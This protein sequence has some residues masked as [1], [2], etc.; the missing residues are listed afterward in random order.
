MNP[1]RFITALRLASDQHLTGLREPFAHAAL[2]AT[3]DSASRT[4]SS[5]GAKLPGSMSQHPSRVV[6]N[7]AGA[8]PSVREHLGT[9]V[10]EI[11]GTDAAALLLGLDESPICAGEGQ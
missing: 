2:S 9:R 3:S 1:E 5:S 7:R 8:V 6:T 10:G 11:A 4:P